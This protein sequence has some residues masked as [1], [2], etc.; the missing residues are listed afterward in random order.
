MR[1]ESGIHCFDQ[2]INIGEH[3]HTE[4]IKRNVMGE[5]IERQTP[6]NY[7]FGIKRQYHFVNREWIGNELFRRLHPDGLTMGEYMQQEV[8]SFDPEIDFH[9]KLDDAESQKRHVRVA[10]SSFNTAFSDTLNSEENGSLNQ[11][12]MFQIKGNMKHGKIIKEW[13]KCM[14]SEFQHHIPREI[15]GPKNFKEYL[16]TNSTQPGYLESESGSFLC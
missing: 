7:P 15:D 4:A 16:L 13:N 12:L 5:I 14:P 9:I 6:I 10:Y 3:T 2:S 11:P 8:L 1:H